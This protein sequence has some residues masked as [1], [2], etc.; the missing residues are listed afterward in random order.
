MKKKI[1]FTLL[2]FIIFII[3]INTASFATF[4]IT[5]FT[6]NSELY[7]NGDLYVKETINYYSNEN[8]N[9]VTRKIITKNSR[10]TTNSADLLELYNVI[11][12]EKVYEQVSYGNLGD[13][14]IFEYTTD[15]NNEYNIK[16]YTPFNSYNKTV[17]YEYVLK[18][19][20]VVYNDTAEIYWNFIGDEWD[21][22]IKNLTINIKLPIQASYKTSYVFGHGSDN[23][24]FEK[25]GNYISLYVQD[26]EAYQPIDARILFSKDAIP[27]SNKIMNKSVLDDYI[28]QEEGLSSEIEDAKVLG[29]L[30][31]NQ[32]AFILTIIVIIEKYHMI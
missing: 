19:V 29:N 27:N 15:G 11:V 25:N 30:S 26:I 10:N 22:N 20:G 8:D 17:E 21:C 7:E 23:G 3:T 4:E 31:V 12:D 1:I 18:N 13:E 2:F 28:N 5:D 9:G 14:G 24:S 32:I 16:V 6:I